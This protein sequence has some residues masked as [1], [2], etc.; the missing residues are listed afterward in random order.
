M[1]HRLNIV[2]I[3][4]GNAGRALAQLLAETAVNLRYDFNCRLAIVAIA[5]Q[6]HGS[7][8]DP[9][10]LDPAEILGQLASGGRF[11]H[12]HPAFSRLAALEIIHTVPAD[13]V[14]EMTPLNIVDARPAIDHIRAAL[15]AGKHVVTLN[16]GPIARAYAQLQALA[17]HAGK[18]LLFEGTVMDGTPLFSLVRDTLPGCRVIAFRGILNSTTNYLLDAMA[19]GADFDQALEKARQLGIAEADPSLDVDGWDAA[20]KTSVLLNVLMDAGVCPQDIERTG[21]GR[22]TPLEL[23]DARAAGHCIKQVCEGRRH[24]GGILGKVAP[25][26]VPASDVLAQTRGTTSALTLT[27][28]LM[29]ELTI[30]EHDPGIHQTAYAVLADLLTIV[31]QAEKQQHGLPAPKSFQS[32]Q[33]RDIKHAKNTHH[34][35]FHQTASLPPR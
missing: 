19:H 23:A 32:T 31:R 10:G 4:F 33:N 30:T 18:R 13:V 26:S 35:Q 25:L 28:D 14:V 15:T 21:I 11:S 2:C 3:G 22:V 7:L 16:K 27:T 8:I 24:Q 6:S 29:G 5:T 1:A 20:A 12:Q 17:V 9:R 34:R